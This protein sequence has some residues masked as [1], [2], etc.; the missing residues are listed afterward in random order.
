MDW[1]EMKGLNRSIVLECMFGAISQV[2]ATRM[3]NVA[4]LRLEQYQAYCLSREGNKTKRNNMFCCMP[5]GAANFCVFHHLE[6]IVALCNLTPLLPKSMSF[7]R[8]QRRHG[9]FSWQC[10]RLE[11]VGFFC[12][13][14]FGMG[15]IIFRNWTASIQKGFLEIGGLAG[16]GYWKRQTRDLKTFVLRWLWIKNQLGYNL[17]RLRPYEFILWAVRN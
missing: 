6:S 10:Q 12:E 3:K 1:N 15:Q 4:A 8:Y 5:T 11:S 7:A 16:L 17:I 2:T 14:C 13:Q 9:H